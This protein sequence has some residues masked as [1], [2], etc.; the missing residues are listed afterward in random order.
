MSK[1]TVIGL[2][3]MGSALAEAFLKKPLAVMVWNRSAARSERLKAQGAQVAPT[4][5]EAI[6]ASD[7]VIVSLSNYAAAREVLGGEDASSA[8]KGKTLIQLSSGTTKE[9]RNAAG[10]AQGHGAKYLDGAILAYPQHIGSAAAQ[11]LLSGSEEIFRQQKELLEV[12]GTPLF[13]SKSPGGAAALDCA[14]LISS[15]CSMISLFYGIA[16]CESEGVASKHVVS[17][18][19]AFL[20]LHGVLN[21][22]MAERIR[23]DNFANPQA[24]VRTWAGVARHFVEIAHE[25]GLPDDVPN[26]IGEVMERALRNGLGELEIS[27]LI[28]VM[29]AKRSH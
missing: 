20:P 15:M 9:G 5:E 26:M 24:T 21:I 8:L 29:R 14:C 7:V 6:S 22:E 18:V 10:W 1:V 2:G 13:V 25:N 3:L 17:L 16:V 12:L 11:I 19:N 4:V 23:K 28:K 27:S